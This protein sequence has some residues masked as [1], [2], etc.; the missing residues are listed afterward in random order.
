[1]PLGVPAATV[2]G[3]TGWFA[4]GGAA[5]VVGAAVGT[6]PVGTLVVGTPPV[7][8]L[9]VGAPLVG[10]APAV[11]VDAPATVDGALWTGPV[12]GIAMEEVLCE[13]VLDELGST[14]APLATVVPDD[15]L[16]ALHAAT[17]NENSATI[18][19]VVL[20][21]MLPIMEERS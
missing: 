21:D 9:V 15:A 16:P 2:V 18:E 3:G 1:M 20:V 5:T 10:W 19:T 12:L 14:D 8:T 13:L 11:V 7:G 6:P 4:D 17:V